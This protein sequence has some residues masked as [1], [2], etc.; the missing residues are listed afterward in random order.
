MKDTASKITTM[1]KFTGQF[2]TNRAGKDR[3]VA[4]VNEVDGKKFNS[5]AEAVTAVVRAVVREEESRYNDRQAMF[6]DRELTKLIRDLAYSLC[7]VQL[8]YPHTTKVVD[9]RTVYSNVN[10]L[11]NAMRGAR[12]QIMLGQDPYDDHKRRQKAQKENKAVEV[13]EEPAKPVYDESLRWHVVVQDSRAIVNTF[14]SRSAAQQ[15]NKD[16]KQSGTNT[17]VVDVLKVA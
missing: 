15:F 14:A 6:N 4:I 10:G 16:Q 9:D 5:K 12:R 1:F 11:E 7:V 8:N 13:V 17:V 2:E 3:S